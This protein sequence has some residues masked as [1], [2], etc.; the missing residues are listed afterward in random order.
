MYFLLIYNDT[1]TLLLVE[2][3]LPHLPF[4]FFLM[5]LHDFDAQYLK[6][7]MQP[8]KCIIFTGLKSRRKFI[9]FVFRQYIHPKSNTCLRLQFY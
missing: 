3:T 7:R 9:Y 8:I 6:Y 4:T 1:I 5:D 2:S